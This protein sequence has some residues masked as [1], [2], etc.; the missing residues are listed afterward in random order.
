VL[1]H[2]QTTNCIIKEKQKEAGGAV[3]QISD[4]AVIDTKKEL[5]KVIK[6]SLM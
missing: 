4:K 6:C 1:T 3:R 5:A 2:T